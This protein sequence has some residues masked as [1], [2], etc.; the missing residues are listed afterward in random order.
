MRLTDEQLARD[1][2]WETALASALGG[3]HALRK[4]PAPLTPDAVAEW[5]PRIVHRLREDV[6]QNWVGALSDLLNDLERWDG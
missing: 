5:A 6:Q 3:Y 4:V 2:E 1:R